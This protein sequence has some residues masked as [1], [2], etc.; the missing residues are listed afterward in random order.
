MKSYTLT[1][2]YRFYVADGGTLPR[3]LYKNICQDFNIKIM[4]HIIYDAGTFDMGN[5]LSTL[6]IRRIKRNFKN[7]HVDWKASND[8]KE[9][10]L[11]E[12]KKL[13]DHE[14]GEGTKWLIYH[15][16]EWYCRFYWKKQHARFKNKSVYKFVATRGKV[17]NKTKLIDHLNENSLNYIK[18]ENASIK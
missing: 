9:E 15:D 4:D 2:M 3:A 8:Y 1:D 13:Y 14:T 12:G 5:Y 7:P 11:A 6:N 16:E 18:Y 10:L 17:G